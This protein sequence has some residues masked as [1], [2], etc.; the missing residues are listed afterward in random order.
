MHKKEIA[1]KVIYR[2]SKILARE[3][4]YDVAVESTLKTMCEHL[5]WKTAAFWM[6]D[7]DCN[8]LFCE[9][10]YSAEPYP[11][12][13]KHSTD[14]RLSRDEGLPGRVWAS[15]QPTWIPDVV[16]D[17]NF[18]RAKSAKEDG[19]HAAFAFPM[20]VGGRFIGVFEFFSDQISQPDEELLSAFAVV[21]TELG[22]FFE[23]Q[24][25]ENALKQQVKLYELSAA[26]G[27]A[28]NQV[29]SLEAMLQSCATIIARHFNAEHV[30]IFAALSEGESPY[31]VA[32]AGLDIR[33]SKETTV[34]QLDSILKEKRPYWT[35]SPLE[36][37]F[38]TDGEWLQKQSITACAFY[39]LSMNDNLLGAI[40]VLTKHKLSKSIIEALSPAANNL[41]LC[42][43]RKM[44]EQHLRVSEGRFRIFANNVD[45]CL[46]VSA[47]LLTK[48][49]YVSPAFEKIFGRPVSEVLADPGIWADKIIPEH[50]ERV[51]KYVSQLTGYQMPEPEIEYAIDLGGELKWLNVKIFA[52]MDQEDG[53]Y[54]ICGSVRDITARKASE[55]RVADF[56]SMVSHEIRTPVNGM[57]GLTTVLSETN[58]DESQVH[59][60]NTIKESGV[61]LLEIVNNILDLSKIEAGRLEL[62]STKFDITHEIE[63]VVK[64]F[65]KLAKDKKLR[66]FAHID[67]QIRHYYFGDPLRLRQIFTNLTNNAL[68]FTSE[69]HVV[70]SAKLIKREESLNRIMVSVTDTGI[71]ISEDQQKRV[72]EDFVQADRTVASKFG[73]TGLGLAICQK[74]ALLMD[75]EITL[76]SKLGCGSTFSME[77]ALRGL[78]TLPSNNES[79]EKTCKV[80]I[81]HSDDAVLAMLK[82]Y[83]C[84]WGAAVETADSFQSVELSADTANDFVILPKLHQSQDGLE[85]LRSFKKK[86]PKSKFIL[87]MDYQAQESDERAAEAGFASSLSLPFS[88]TDLFNCLRESPTF[89]FSPKSTATPDK[90]VTPKISGNHKILVMED[91]PVNK[92][93]IAHFLKQ[94]NVEFDLFPDGRAG[95]D[96]YLAAAPALYDLILTDC[97]MPE[98]DGFELTR[99]IRGLSDERARIPIIA[100]T[101]SAM[102]SDQE[103]CIEAGMNDYISKPI[104][105]DYLRLVLEKW[106]SAI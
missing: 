102:K 62:D 95:L 51:M 23:R 69:G 59:Y 49:Y 2:V 92:Q 38:F 26:I 1:Q 103:K 7:E 97:Q 13:E 83:L 22:Q 47:P 105:R 17:S 14:I 50:K 41:A 71:G 61:G 85:F 80:L 99:Q 21:G 98:M 78:E 79:L 32:S 67:P 33:V 70:I 81:V 20:S 53:T 74:I 18:P 63:L 88:R 4:D 52:V 43:S 77:V 90:S 104:D 27:S 39:P 72:F 3:I 82:D 94:L 44:A 19:L 101:A 68:K 31:L 73:G 96:A 57:L 91:H 93:V 42:I 16:L 86:N 54:H 66:L 58:L 84:A 76:F 106:F 10:F 9:R 48:H 75:S 12:F 87:L 55:K 46:F 100:L 25:I 60:V 40:V 56:Y 5:G 37:G 8:Q 65:T 11:E 89:H 64:V 35:N 30:G 15:D 6:L 36:E 45:E 24:R 29:D 34:L 28:V